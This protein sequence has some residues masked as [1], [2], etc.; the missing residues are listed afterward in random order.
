M[1][2]T[3]WHEIIRLI[4]LTGLVLLG[5]IPGTVKA[6]QILQ[7]PGLIISI[8]D[9]TGYISRISLKSQSEGTS[10]NVDLLVD[11]NLLSLDWLI[12]PH[13]LSNQ[14]ISDD[15]G[16]SLVESRYVNQGLTILRRVS[17]GT[18]PYALSI[19]YEISNTSSEVID[20]ASILGSTFH[21]A[22]GFNEFVDEGG[23]YGAWV[24][25][26]R[27][28][29]VSNKNG[30]QKL[31]REELKELST[32]EPIQWLGW[33]NRHHVM[34]IR[35]HQPRSVGI[36]VKETFSSI[37]NTDKK[38]VPASLA[39]T[40]AHSG[41]TQPEQLL[42]GE[43]TTIAFDSVI[44]PKQWD[45]LSFV[46]PAL[47]SVVLLNLWGWF[48]LIC[49]AIWELLNFL[50]GLAG[51]WGIAIILMALVVRILIIPVTRIS[52]QYQERAIQ[53]QERIKP[54][55]KRVKEEYKGIELSKQLVSL[56]EREKY[57]QLAPF[58]GMLGLFI[59]IPILIAL[60]NV[61][62][63]ASEVSRVPFLWFHDL[64]LSDRLFPLGV[65]LPFF[66]AYFNLLPF[67][68]AG[69]TVLSTYYAAQTAS[70]NTSTSSLF[71][72]A[73]LF[74]ILFY[75][76]P[77]ALVLYWLCSTCFQFMQ[78]VIENRMK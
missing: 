6:A 3:R 75:S 22:E 59:Q 66:G 13:L 64:A 39:L 8:D 9:E 47:D 55:I 23:G 18:S 62:G 61:L 77:S 71:G 68:M 58:K 15:V 17:G 53:Q 43:A 70:N 57:D 41:Q 30:A 60:F 24:Y 20:L 76:F 16:K 73:A 1:W 51:S 28:L 10:Q 4:S 46:T 54:L 36:G 14:Y 35:L 69:V 48:R 63:E 34:A 78:Q 26:Y 5:L 7:T 49:F 40:F 27:D 21:F 65:D 38:L 29:F 12:Q 11:G 67:L 72:M 19:R 2:N 32:L 52:L 25:A 56:Y 45:K 74:F 33:V 50:F 31:D 44:A 37:E 42:P